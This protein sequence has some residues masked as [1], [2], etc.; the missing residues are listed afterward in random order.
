MSVLAG[1]GLGAV[2]VVRR[3][4]R[5]AAVGAAGRGPG[6]G[7]AA[8]LALSVLATVLLSVGVR[9]FVSANQ[10]LARA[11]AEGEE[12]SLTLQLTSSPRPLETA[13]GPRQFIFDAVV[14]TATAH[15]RQMS[16]RL[17]IR[18]VAGAA[19]EHVPEGATATTAGKIVPAG[20]REKVAGYLRPATAPQQVHGGGS[21]AQPIRAAW[22][23]SSHRVWGQLSKDTAGLLPGMVMGDRSG[24]APPLAQAMKTVGLTHLTAVSGENCSLVLAAVLLMLRSAR[25]HRV[26]AGGLAVLGLLGFV[27][28]VGPDPSVLRAAVMGGLGALAMVG[29]RP[30]RVGAL[31]SIS[32]VVL[33]VEDP[34][35][36]VDYAFTLSVLATLG[37]H[38][39]GRRCAQWLGAWMPAWLAQAVAIPLA[40]QLFCAPVIVLLQARFTPYTIPANMA[41]APL[42][43]LVTTVGTL[44]MVVAT[45]V[46]FLADVCA[47]ISGVGAWWVGTVAQWMSALPAASLPWPAGPAGMVLMALMNSAVVAFLLAVVER[48][49][50]R[51]LLRDAR[52]RLPRRWRFLT[53]FGVLT[54]VATLAAGLWTAAMVGL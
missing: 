20:L 47:G 22:V 11:V 15:G 43:A 3:R 50:A 41:A 12:L 5:D 36:A 6:P 45:V 2:M 54:A 39:L 9:Q 13:Q 42:V 44:G 28:V 17:A 49:R 40:A 53:E 14:R 30:G 25:V 27:A 38:V 34:W 35:L 18:V 10:P 52:A 1:T 16:G 32:I 46:P 51:A 24:V 33:L 48:R 7:P 21:W 8:I 4:R 31:L 37:L 19:W 29:G 23:S 26:L